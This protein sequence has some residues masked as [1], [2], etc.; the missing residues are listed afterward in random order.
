MISQQD[1]EANFFDIETITSDILKSQDIV[2]A[3]KF[4]YYFM[5][6]PLSQRDLLLV[7][8][9]YHNDQFAQ[10]LL[11]AVE[12]LD[13]GQSVLSKHQIDIPNEY[14]FTHLLLVPPDFHSYFKGRLDEERKELYLVLPI[15]NCEYSGSELKELF[16]EMRHH[17]NPALDWRR[18]ITPKA[19]LRFENP[20]TQGGAGSSSGVP[21]SFTMIDQEIRNLNG[22]ESG[23][24]EVFGF[25]DD[26]VEIQSPNQDV[27][28]L[29]SQYDE[30]ARTMSQKEVIIAVWEFLVQE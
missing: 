7:T 14:N 1:I 26:Y 10:S 16:V 30:E 25:R 8:D 27:Y 11:L 2:P 9:G 17:T 18:V 24:M 21:V 15:H 12:Q 5:P 29:R 13:G 4:L 28:T 6:D 20:R 22:V 3:F 23:F 19:L